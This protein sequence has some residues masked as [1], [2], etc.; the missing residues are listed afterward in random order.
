MYCTETATHY[1][2]NKLSQFK[3]IAR[4]S[5]DVDSVQVQLKMI[6]VFLEKPKYTPPHLSDVPRIKPLKQFQCLSSHTLTQS[7][8]L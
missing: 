2:R 6:S 7:H 3:L 8:S 5:F 4:I 1:P